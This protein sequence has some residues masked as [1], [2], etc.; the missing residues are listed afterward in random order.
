[1]RRG[2]ASAGY[3]VHAVPSVILGEA[4]K[5]QPPSF[6]WTAEHQA[7]QQYGLDRLDLQ[8]ANQ[9]QH[10][11]KAIHADKALDAEDMTASQVG[12]HGFCCQ[13]FI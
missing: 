1:L 11:Y 9:Q 5:G 10:G 8:L 4:G 2:Y 3:D 12:D 6:H 13:A 7:V